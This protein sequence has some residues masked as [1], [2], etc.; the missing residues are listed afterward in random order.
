MAV[1]NKDKK[2]ATDKAYY[3]A[4]KEKLLL[5]MKAYNKANRAQANAYCKK[6]DEANKEKLRSA[7][8]KRRFGITLEDY[9]KMFEDQKGCC[10]ICNTHQLDLKKRL[11]V[12]HCHTTGKVRGLLCGN[13]N[14]AIGMLNDSQELLLSAINYLKNE[15][16]DI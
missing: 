16:N 10:K 6:Y 2:K 3:E 8:Y 4:N 15:T 1:T 11:A 5:T 13:C 12:D 9:N 14:R 7:A